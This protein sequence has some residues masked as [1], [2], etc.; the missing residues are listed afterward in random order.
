MPF[1]TI[2]TTLDGVLEIEPEIF[3]DRRGHFLE[4]YR[5]ED[6]TAIGI[7][8]TFVQ[9]NRSFSRKGVLRG[10]HFQSP[11]HEQGKLVSTITGKIF[12]VAVD[13]R[14]NS[15][16]FAKWYSTILSGENSR[17]LWIPPGF[18]HGFAALEDSNVMYKVTSQYRKEA[19]SGIRWN[20]SNLKID[21]PL[22]NPIVSEKDLSLPELADVFSTMR[23][24]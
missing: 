5:L 2:Y 9:D 17:M 8:H 18:A 15:P 20:D 23:E 11:P 4:S 3:S 19:E 10:L 21:W 6:F 24:I 1:K 16:T 12:D 13:I 22:S 7:E 14:Q